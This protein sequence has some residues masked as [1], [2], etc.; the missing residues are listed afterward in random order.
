MPSDG[1][2][3]RRQADCRCVV[4]LARLQGAD[5]GLDDGLRRGEIR[6]TD[7]HVHNGTALRFEFAGR[8]P[9]TP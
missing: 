4:G 5:T 8:A 9:A 6:F 7:F 2:A 3:Q 1:F